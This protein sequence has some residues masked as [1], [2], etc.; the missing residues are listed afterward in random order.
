MPACGVLATRPI[1]QG[2][3]V[4]AYGYALSDV[5]A[6]VSN[7]AQYA[8]LGAGANHIRL[9]PRGKGCLGMGVGF[10]TCGAQAGPGRGVRSSAGTR[11]RSE[12]CHFSPVFIF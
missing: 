5:Y 3:L 6:Y 7:Q 4:L 10:G 9:V 8:L 12:V 11:G 2:G 1:T